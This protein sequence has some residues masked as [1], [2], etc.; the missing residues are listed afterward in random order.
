M[1][2]YIQYEIYEHFHH[3]KITRFMVYDPGNEYAN[4]RSICMR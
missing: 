1:T 3:T 4:Y 2:P